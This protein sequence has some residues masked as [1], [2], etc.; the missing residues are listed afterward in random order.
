MTKNRVSTVNKQ[1]KMDQLDGEFNKIKPSNFDGES[2]TEEK[3]E[4]WLLDI[5]KYF[6][7]YN[8]SSNMKERMVFYNLNKLVYYSKI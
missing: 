3:A 4:A 6:H 7:I 2:K 5:N 1:K 8:Y